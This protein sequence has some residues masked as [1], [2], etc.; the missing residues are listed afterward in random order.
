MSSSGRRLGGGRVLGS[1]RSLAPAVPVTLKPPPSHQSNLN[2]NLAVSPSESSVS[3]SSQISTPPS[4]Q[5]NQDL[6]SRVSLDHG[7]RSVA[8]AQAAAS[9]KLVCPICDEEMV[10]QGFETHFST[11][12]DKR[13]RSRCSS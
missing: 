13:D 8:A 11:G 2:L 3:L 4:T 10:S 7:A 5:E 1:G 9:D 6:S 12:T